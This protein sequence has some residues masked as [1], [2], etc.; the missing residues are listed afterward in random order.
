[1]VM[2]APQFFENQLKEVKNHPVV[3][4]R[5]M[6]IAFSEYNLHYAAPGHSLAET[7]DL[8][9]ALSLAELYQVFIRQNVF[10]ADIWAV[11]DNTE[12]AL[13]QAQGSVNRKSPAYHV[14]SLYSRGFGSQLVDSQIQQNPTIDVPPFDQQKTV[15]KIPT[16]SAVAALN[17]KGDTLSLIV[18]NKDLK[19]AIT[20]NVNLSGFT[21]TG[22]VTTWT[23]SGPDPNANNDGTKELVGTDMRTVSGSTA[24]RLPPLSVTKIQWVK[25][26]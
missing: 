18:V 11:Y 2:A 1:M 8:K 5:N 15:T 25:A 14:F 3:K 10:M 20:A 16:L 22:Q 7:R 19:A 23:V 17:D 21:P 12:K 6:K 24:F 26:R 9:S 4:S 13:I